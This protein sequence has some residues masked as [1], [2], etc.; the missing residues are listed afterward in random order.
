M[1]WLG[2][3]MLAAVLVGCADNRVNQKKPPEI[4]VYAT[5]SLS[6][7]SNQF[8]ALMLFSD[9]DA[10]FV[11]TDLNHSKDKTTHFGTWQRSSSYIDLIL[12]DGENLSLLWQGNYLI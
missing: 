7:E 8:V 12:A 9:G 5:V 6:A 3:L 11:E 4:Q 10:L 2:V 1:R